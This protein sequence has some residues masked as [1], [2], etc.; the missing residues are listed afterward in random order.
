MGLGVT[1]IKGCLSLPL[2]DSAYFPVSPA[3]GSEWEFT[4]TLLM[5]SQSST[6][7]SGRLRKE[8]TGG[9]EHSWLQSLPLAGPFPLVGGVR[10]LTDSEGSWEWAGT[11]LSP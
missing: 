1:V 9:Q 4:C 10:R 5:T 3:L 11:W 8:K 7:E 6:S 2:P